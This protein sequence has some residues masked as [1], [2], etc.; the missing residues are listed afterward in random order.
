MRSRFRRLL[1]VSVAAGLMA[2]AG[3]VTVISLQA[4]VPL[5]GSRSEKPQDRPISTL[6]DLNQAFIDISAT[7]K[8]AVVTVSTE[9]TLRAQVGSPFGPQL[10]GDPFLDMFFGPH[11]GQ[12]QPRE[13]DYRQQGLGSGVIVSS[14]GRILTNNHVIDDVD[15]I[16][17]RTFNGERYP[18]ESGLHSHARDCQ[19]QGAFQR[20]SG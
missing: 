10:G 7:V 14:D 2:V 16:F 3:L 20:W 11:G 13:Q 15:S 9:K 4:Q 1:T 6:R 5:P 19:R 17:V 18:R 12:Q 8:A